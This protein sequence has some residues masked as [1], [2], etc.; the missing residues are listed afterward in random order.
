[1]KRSP[2]IALAATLAIGAFG[3]GAAAAPVDL[4]SG[5]SGFYS[6]PSEGVFSDLYTFTL[7]ST[8]TVNVMLSSVVGGAQDVDLSSV[9]L[10]GPQGAVLNASSFTGNPFESWIIT[11]ALLAPGQYTLTA[12]GVNSGA[13]GT[14]DGS[15]ALSGSSAAPFT[16]GGCSELHDEP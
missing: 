10:T 6:T 3:V 5:S 15:I 16:G 14:Y 8:Q 2:A 12:S 7:A 4:S 1:M 11:D 13:S 9:F